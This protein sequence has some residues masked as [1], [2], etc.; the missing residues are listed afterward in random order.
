VGGFS[1]SS[2]DG[3]TNSG[4][5]D[6]FVIKYNPD[7]SKAWTRLVGGSGNETGYALTTGTDGSIYL[8]GKTVSTT[9]DGQ[10]NSGGEDAFVT[11]FTPDGTKVWTRLFGG[12]GNEVARVVATA[13]DSGIIVSGFTTSSTLD[14]QTVRG[15]R[16]AFITKYKPDGT[17]D[18]TRLLG[19]DGLEEG[20]GLAIDSS[21]GVY[22]SGL[23]APTS[24]SGQEGSTSG[25]TIGATLDGQTVSGQQDAFII[26]LSHSTSASATSTSVFTGLTVDLSTA[27]ATTTALASIDAALYSFTATARNVRSGLIRA[28]RSLSYLA[29]S[30]E[31]LETAVG[32]VGPQPA[33]VADVESFSSSVE[34]QKRLLGEV[35]QV[36]RRLVNNFLS[37]YIGK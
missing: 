33:F 2:F 7:G 15:G 25:G 28:N 32:Q 8:S 5:Y 30:G 14:G 4:G 37:Q 22:V 31:S 29:N 6:A 12:S 9:L 20:D 21:G 10:T 34:E 3:L 23:T 24:A 13:I 35:K 16:D 11:K 27:N 36:K 26:K 19:G 17:K 18:W 1:N